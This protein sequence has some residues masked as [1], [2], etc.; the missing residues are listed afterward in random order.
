[1]RV[2]LMGRYAGPKARINRRLSAQI[3]ES[4]GARRAHERREQPPGMHTRVPR[5][6]DYAQA[7]QEEQKIKHYYR[8]RERQLRRYFQVASK[9]AANTGETLLQLCE[10]RLDNVI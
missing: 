6:L 3:Y 1:R 7:L 4:S 2:A 5:L 8:S 10:R 9:K